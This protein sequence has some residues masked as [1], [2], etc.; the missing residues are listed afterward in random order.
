MGWVIFYA[1]LLLSYVSAS[2]CSLLYPTRAPEF[3]K[4]ISGSVALLT[5]LLQAISR[6]NLKVY[7]LGQRIS[8]WWH[9][10]RTALW[11]FALRLDGNFQSNVIEQTAAA[12]KT[13]VDFK[14]WQPEIFFV[15]DRELRAKLDKTVHVHLMF[16]PAAVSADGTGHLLIRSDEFEVP[17]G[18]ARRKIDRQLTPLLTV[19]STFFRPQNSSIEFEVAFNKRNPFFAFYVAHLRPEQVTHFNLVFRPNDICRQGLARVS[20]TQNTLEI[21][22]GTAEG[23]AALAKAFVLLTAEAAKFAEAK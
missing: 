6:V 8:V 2:A 23:F 7:L 12:L 18:A 15:N 16:E 14:G 19:F 9:G 1:V 20:V 17:Y 13:G 5:G 3:I 4:A 21:S 22:T 10:D 11:R